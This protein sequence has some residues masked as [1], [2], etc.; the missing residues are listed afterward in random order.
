MS[1]LKRRKYT[2]EF[3]SEAVRLVEE[4]G[5]PVAEIARELGVAENLLYR[6]RGEE[7]QAVSR[8]TTRAALKADAE[9]LVRLRRELETVKRERDFLKSAAAY[10]ARERK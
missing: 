5:K 6:W 7:H 1:A 2:E 9:E 3:K 4:S 8:G 10:F